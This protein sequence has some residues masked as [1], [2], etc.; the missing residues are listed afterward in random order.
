MLSAVLAINS[1][2]LP[3][4]EADS[5][6]DSFEITRFVVEG[7]SVLPQPLIDATL[8]PLL[9]KERDFSHVQQALEALDNAY[10]EQGYNAVHVSVPEQSLNRGVVRLRVVEIRVG[11]L[12][13]EGNAAFDEANIRRSL[14]GLRL[15]STPNILEVAAN[16]KLAND[17]P[18]KRTSVQL[19]ESAG[20]DGRSS[21]DVL[22]RTTG[23]KAWKLGLSLDN[24]GGGA[25]SAMGN[26]RAGVAYQHANVAGLDHVAR[27]QFITSLEQPGQ[28]SAYGAAYRIPL[29]SLGDSVD[30]VANHSEAGSG[31]ISVGPF[32]LHARGTG[33]ALAARYNRHL[34]QIGDLESRLIFGID[35]RAY[36]NDAPVS[37][38]PVD[39]SIAV[40][41]LSLAYAGR[42]LL[43]NAETTFHVS[44]AHNLPGGGK[45]SA[46]E[47]GRARAG[48]DARYT[49]LRYGA[50]L[51]LDLPAD[52]QLSLNGAGQYTR[53][54]LVWTE[55]FTLGGARS[56]RG[57]READVAND[58]GYGLSAQMQTPELCAG[59]LPYGA[60][61]RAV[62]F[63]DAGRVARNGALPGEE[64]RSS[65]ASIGLG[66]RLTVGQDASINIDYARVIDGG[67][68]S[69]GGEQ[70]VHAGIAIS[71]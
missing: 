45:G 64:L 59:S 3:A 42:W 18:A 11:S 63:Y 9:G 52:W 22:V 56:V 40:H 35:H 36:S 44:L 47:L 67:G 10:R 28:A 71:Y 39:H 14:P 29:Y 53:D 15:G 41:P 50:K 4:A 23:D 17:N 8:A 32:D 16:L 48:A 25:S 55:Q 20:V 54:R 58:K 12:R 19:R 33:T 34:R 38:V 57:F 21:M 5:A 13:I 70:R 1:G 68:G 61:C 2:S 69:T 60:L 30:V 6:T 26:A 51:R 43:D 37:G 27:L 7:N 24:A 65:I 49:L 62:G 46:A 66:L 31:P